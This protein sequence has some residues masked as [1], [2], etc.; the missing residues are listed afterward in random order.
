[1]RS[2]RTTAKRPPLLVRRQCRRRRREPQPLSYRRFVQQG[3]GWGVRQGHSPMDAGARQSPAR[4]AVVT[5]TRTKGDDPPL[6]L[7]PGWPHGTDAQVGALPLRGSRRERRRRAMRAPRR[8]RRSAAAPRPAAAP[9]HAPLDDEPKHLDR[10]KA[11]VRGLDASVL[12][13]QGPPGTGGPWTGRGSRSTCSSAAPA[14]AWPRR[15][16]RRSTTCWP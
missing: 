5:R 10:L 4:T 7:A 12:M 9:G 16:T 11:Q 3:F 1:M 2:G 15:R 14:S 8:G 13:V 6:A